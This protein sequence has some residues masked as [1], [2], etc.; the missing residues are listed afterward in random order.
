MYSNVD[1]CIIDDVELWS[2]ASYPIIQS[3]SFWILLHL[4]DLSQ[5]CAY[6]EINYVIR[7]KA[8][9]AYKLEDIIQEMDHDSEKE[10]RANLDFNL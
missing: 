2:E 4:D 10:S 6:Y 8:R 5:Y 3:I 9:K 1:E 7:N